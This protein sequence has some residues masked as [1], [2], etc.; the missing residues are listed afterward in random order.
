[1]FFAALRCF[2]SC[3][4]IASVCGWASLCA[5]LLVCSPGFA[6]VGA[7]TPLTLVEAEQL[8]LFEEPGRMAFGEQAAAARAQAVAAGQLPDPTL[9]LGAANL[10][11][12]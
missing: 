6:T 1:M 8:A 10:P 12:N 11:I 7:V 9:R 5:G 3:R 2:S 4:S